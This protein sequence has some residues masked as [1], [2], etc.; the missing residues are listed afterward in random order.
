MHRRRFLSAAGTAAVAALA[1][2]SSSEPTTTGTDGGTTDT[3][4]TPSSPTE[5]P[6][7]SPTDSPTPAGPPEVAVESSEL[8]T[9]E[10]DTFDHTVVHAEV[11]NTGGA[12][13]GLIEVEAVFYDD[14]GEELDANS[15]VL[16]ALPAGDTWEVYVQ[17]LGSESPADYEVDLAH[18]SS[19]QPDWGVEGAEVVESTLDAS[20]DVKVNGTVKNTSE[21]TIDYLEVVPY[22]YAENGNLLGVSLSNETD[23]E[24]GA[25]WEF[26]TSF[27]VGIDKVADRVSDH[28]VHLSGL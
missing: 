21:S 1:G 2:C 17:Y 4:G 22:F 7:D 11:S 23:L 20:G 25:T 26:S 10:G 27:L 8:T 16:P 14:G 24:A 9:I 6:T 19:T 5:S 13:S 18:D 15:N 3:D 12:V 28:E